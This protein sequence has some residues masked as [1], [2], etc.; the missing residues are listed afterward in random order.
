MIVWGVC[1]RDENE[2]FEMKFF[3]LDQLIVKIK[4]IL[5]K[6]IFNSKIDFL[7]NND[8]KLMVKV[9]FMK[10]FDQKIFELRGKI[11]DT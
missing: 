10:E 1:W 5:N 2:I 3:E 6:N 4:L 8:K 9:K 7:R 11:K